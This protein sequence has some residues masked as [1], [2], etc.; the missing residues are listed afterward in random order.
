M[1]IDTHTHINS[2]VVPN[3]L[4]SI[5]EINNDPYLQKV[6]NVGLDLDTSSECKDISILNPKIYYSVGIHPLYIDGQDVNDLRDLIT[7]KAV[8]IGEAGFDD[9]KKNIFEQR[10]YF[11]KQIMLA[12]EAGL[13]LIIHANNGNKN[14]IEVF[15]TVVKPEYGCVFHCFQPDVDL[16]DY[17][18]DNSYYISFAGRVTYKNANRALKVLERIP[19][20]LFMVE[21]DS[22]FISPEPVRYEAGTSSNLHYIVERI[23]ELKRLKPSDIEAITNENAMRL[24]RKLR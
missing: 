20:G 8:G 1:A 7:D 11:I 6:I 19:Y 10:T 13:P 5:M 4:K 21:T 3:V 14:V 24:F 2:T 12:N 22:P 18:V 17:I 9:G 15:E 23:A 16:L